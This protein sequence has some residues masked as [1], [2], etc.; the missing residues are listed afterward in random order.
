MRATSKPIKNVLRL[1]EIGFT[2]LEM[3]LSLLVF[4]MIASMLPLSFRIILDDT[5]T[6]KG[7]TRMEWDVFSSQIKK[8]I[9]TAEQMTVQPDKLLLKVNGQIILY[10]KYASSMRRRVDGQGHE[11]LMQNLSSFAFEKIADGVVVT[12]VGLDG[13]HYSVRIHQFL[14]TGGVQL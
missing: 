10:E 5:L 13:I 2:M 8:E 12:A 3:L 14:Q 4:S 1:N 6:E 9:R 7:L 11:I